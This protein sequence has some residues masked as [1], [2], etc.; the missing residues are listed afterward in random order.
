MRWPYYISSE[1]KKP[2]KETAIFAVI[3]KDFSGLAL[4][5][6]DGAYRRGR[7]AVFVIRSSR[8]SGFLD[9]TKK[10]STLENET[11]SAAKHFA[12]AR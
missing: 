8:V 1:N 7:V 10:G 3:L 12:K 4:E 2:F 9:R 6:V 11:S 5:G